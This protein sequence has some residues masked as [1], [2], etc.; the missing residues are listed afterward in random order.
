MSWLRWT[1]M[2]CGLEFAEAADG[3]ERI[4]RQTT[5]APESHDAPVQVMGPLE[6]AG[7]AFD[8]VWFLRGGD[9]SWPME[10]AS[11]A[12]LPWALQRDLGM[13]GA[14]VARDAEYARRIT[15]RI[16]EQ[17]GD[18]D[19]QLRTRVRGGEQ[20]SFACA[21]GAWTEGSRRCGAGGGIRLSAVVVQLEEMDD[22]QRV[23]CRRMA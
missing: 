21:C 2:G 7:G 14:D 8:A 13:P 18:G 9:L 15:E 3:L 1:S 6:A 12:L 10:T 17:R 23:S 20:R 4:A 16:A 22:M 11:S 19:L 5:F